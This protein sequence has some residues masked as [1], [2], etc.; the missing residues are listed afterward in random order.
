VGALR[1]IKR[2][3]YLGDHQKLADILA[4]GLNELLQQRICALRLA[5]LGTRAVVLD[6]LAQERSGLG[7]EGAV[8]VE[9][10]D[11]FIELRGVL[12]ARVSDGRS[13]AI[14]HLLQGVAKQGKDL[15]VGGARF[16]VGVEL[17]E[18]HK[19]FDDLGWLDTMR[20]SIGS[21]TM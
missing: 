5:G 14:D 11:H 21:R 8:L 17:L 20:A 7:E 6:D 10:R 12:C 2:V 16:G 13:G 18:L 19:G 15:V 9:R 4:L 1:E 3:Q